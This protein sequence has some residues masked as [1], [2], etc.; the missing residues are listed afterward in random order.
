MQNLDPDHLDDITSRLNALRLSNGGGFSRNSS[1]PIASAP[2]LTAPS[3]EIDSNELH[4]SQRL[5]NGNSY[6]GTGHLNDIYVPQQTQHVH[7]EIPTDQQ[8][9]YPDFSQ[10]QN[11]QQSHQMNERQRQMTTLQAQLHPQQKQIAQYPAQMEHQDKI[12]QQT[13]VIPPTQMMQPGT[14]YPPQYLS[15]LPEYQHQYVGSPPPDKKEHH[16][17]GLTDENSKWYSPPGTVAAR[18][19]KTPVQVIGGSSIRR[20]IKEIQREQE[21][22]EHQVAV[23]RWQDVIKSSVNKQL[24]NDYKNAERFISE[25][26]KQIEDPER[27]NVLL[28][29]MSLHVGRTMRFGDQKFHS[30][31]K[32]TSIPVS[33]EFRQKRWMKCEMKY[34]EEAIKDFNKLPNNKNIVKIIIRFQKNTGVI[35]FIGFEI[36]DNE[37]KCLV[38][39]KKTGGKWNGTTYYET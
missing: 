1:P 33:D 2:P 18:N 39:S 6:N 31:V 5:I 26:R 30:G 7:L 17:Y 20:E 27:F 12:M 19:G 11:P 16:P 3:S 28:R 34:I 24:E 36:L 4:E 23:L 10:F 25:I 38:L 37:L 29:E 15:H 32:T 22:Q 9:A 8:I 35:N 14:H 21:Y 13:R